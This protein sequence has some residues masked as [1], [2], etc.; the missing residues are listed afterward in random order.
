MA[1]WIKRH[2]ALILLIVFSVI[3]RLP[4]LFE[5]YWYGD[6]GIYLVL[7]QAL[8]KGLVWYRDIHDNKPPLLYL[9]AAFTGTVFWF[10][11]L[12]IVWFGA[13]LVFFYRLAQKLLP[14]IPAAW[15]W[16]TLALIILTTVFEGNIAN[17]EIFIVLPVTIAMLLA[18]RARPN[19]LLIGLPFSLG[20]LF[21]VPAVFDFFALLLWLIF[22]KKPKFINLVWA[23]LGFAVPILLTMAYYGWQGG[24]EPY[25]RSALM[26][27]IGYLASWSTG[28][29]STSGFTSQ[30]GLLTRLAVIVLGSVIFIPL[31][32]KFKLSAATGLVVI[33][34]GWAMFGALLSERPYPHY[35][36]QPAVPLA[37]L[38][39]LLFFG[40]RRLLR[41]IILAVLAA[42][43]LAYYQ[44]RFWHYPII[45]YYQ[46]FISWSLGQKS[47]QDYRNWFGPRVN[48]NYRLAEYLRQTIPAGESIFVWGDE[49]FVYALSNRLPVG[50]YTVAYHVIDFNGFNSILAAWD[51]QPPRAVIV[52]QGESR[53]F[54]GLF[55]RLDT[56]Y[57]SVLTFGEAQ[58]YRRLDGVD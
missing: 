34:F 21:K 9:L 23:G 17:A 45:A 36:I 54:P 20:F 39:V 12:L 7:G 57:V 55:A 42:A 40:G 27:N 51:K 28:E 15:N 5:P 3:L 49:P 38:L 25:V 24:F 18:L 14:Q 19:Y 8:K 2:E 10:R 22:W 35:L 16:A 53:G 4:S 56:N 47:V 33:W 26:Q 30:G 44:I 13:T 50:R 1:A 41:L 52:Y 43:L 32:K 31:A 11:L 46:N 58:V 48:N 29:H 6:E 37:T